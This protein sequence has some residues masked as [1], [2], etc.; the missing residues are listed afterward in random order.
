MLLSLHG[1]NK[2]AFTKIKMAS[3]EYDILEPWYKCNMSDMAAALG[4]TQLRRYPDMLGRRHEIIKRYDDAF[5][6]LPV[7][8]LDHFRHDQKSSGHLYFLRINN[9]SESQRNQ[10]IIKMAEQGVVCNV[11]YKPLPMLSA[12]S[13]RGFLIEDYPNSYNYYKNMVTL[14]LYSTLTDEQVDY[15]ISCVRD[16]LK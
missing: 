15:I 12:Y 8:V 5:V 9:F 1:Q 10:F 2:D 7:Q 4:Q 3:W 14:P 16:I 6:D 11:H 13:K